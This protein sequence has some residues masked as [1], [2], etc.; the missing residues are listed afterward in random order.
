MVPN[1]NLANLAD[2]FDFMPILMNYAS[3]SFHCKGFQCAFVESPGSILPYSKLLFGCLM[4]I[5]QYISS[6]IA[7][8]GNMRI[9][10]ADPPQLKVRWGPSRS[11]TNSL[12]LL[13]ITYNVYRQ[14]SLTIIYFCEE[15]KN[16]TAPY[17]TCA[18]LIFLHRFWIE[19]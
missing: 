3:G 19:R 17:C 9:W 18:C 8:N 12:K 13:H 5:Q 16:F 4:Y 6:N 11:I 2:F 7:Q 15:K 1:A 14:L 10:R